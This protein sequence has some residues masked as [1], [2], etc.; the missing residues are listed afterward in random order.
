[1]RRARTLL[2]RLLT[3]EVIS[4]SNDFLPKESAMSNAV[5]AEPCSPSFS[6][7]FLPKESGMSMNAVFAEPYAISFSDDIK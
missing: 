6:N 7:D 4:F 3:P 5:F 2:S 1:M